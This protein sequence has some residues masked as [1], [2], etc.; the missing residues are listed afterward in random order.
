MFGLEKIK[1]TDNK[2]T[3]VQT[4][5]LRVKLEKLT[6]KELNKLG[7]MTKD[8]IHF[9]SM[10]S[11]NCTLSAA[12]Y[13]YICLRTKC[14]KRKQTPMEYFSYIFTITYSVPNITAQ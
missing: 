3:L 5:F 8:L 9:L 4:T 11:R 2:L 7:I 13:T 12:L 6:E 10:N 14:Q 1:L